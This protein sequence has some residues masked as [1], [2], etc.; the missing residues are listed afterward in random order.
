MLYN[1]AIILFQDTLNRYNAFL[2]RFSFLKSIR[3]M[4]LIENPHFEQV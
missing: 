1:S 2:R 4:L 3:E